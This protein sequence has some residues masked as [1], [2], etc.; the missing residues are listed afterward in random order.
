MANL[1]IFID[2]SGTM[3]LNNEKTIFA[4]AGIGV[5]DDYPIFTGK[6]G[7]KP[8]LVGQILKHSAI[9]FISYIDPDDEYFM[10]INKKLNDIEKMA[11]ATLK[12]TGNNKNYFSLYGIKKRNMLW[13]LTVLNCI[14]R[15]ILNATAKDSIDKL[16][17]YLDQKTLHP[18]S[19]S[20]FKN[21]IK[22]ELDIICGSLKKIENVPINILALIN[23]RLN[24][25]KD[26][27]RVIWSNET[28]ALPAIYGL[29]IA[30]YLSSYFRK[31]YNKGYIEESIQNRLKKAGYTY[32]S[33]KMNALLTKNFNS[34][35]IQDWE[36]NTGL[37]FDD[38]N[39]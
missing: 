2:E 28:E 31:D 33:C 32:H 34:T 11:T 30:H 6:K 13:I 10:K 12:I 5:F 39:I 29:K 7:Y 24:W 1:L 37:T 26:E 18:T 14:G 15:I 23:S 4:A 25:D 21:Q 36:K 22:R 20:L 27:I 19:L 3:P 38:I 8:W 35:S 17:I 9:P 16:S